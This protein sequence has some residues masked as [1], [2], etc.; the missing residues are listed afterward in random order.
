L[1][2]GRRPCGADGGLAERTAA[3]LSISDFIDRA[4][5]A[6]IATHL[7]AQAI[8]HPGVALGAADDEQQRQLGVPPA[9]HQAPSAVLL[10]TAGPVGW[11][12]GRGE[13]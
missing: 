13:V 6:V 11:T 5:G 4:S 8:A 12:L 1:R 3:R 2:S 10:L 9:A 7:P